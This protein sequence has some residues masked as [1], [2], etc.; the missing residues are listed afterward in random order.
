MTL[1]IVIDPLKGP[2]KTIQEGIDQAKPGST[3]KIKKGN[4]L[5]NLMISTE[6]ITLKP[7]DQG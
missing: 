5:E 4:Y 2:F 7:F 6:N 1:E 3:I